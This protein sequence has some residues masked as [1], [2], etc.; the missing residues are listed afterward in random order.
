MNENYA[1]T[2]TG[3]TPGPQMMLAPAAVPPAG[4]S[5]DIAAIADAFRRRWWVVALAAL[6][7]GVLALAAA[8]SIE[9][10]Y[11]SHASV[12]V[13][14]G[15][16]R[17]LDFEDI[18]PED[19]SHL[20]VL[21]T[22]EQT[23]HSSSLLLRVADACGLRTQP[24]FMD[25]SGR[26]HPDSRLVYLLRTKISV[27][28]RRGTRLI[29][30]VVSDTVPER[31]RL[32]AATMVS[33][34]ERWEAEQAKQ[35]SELAHG[36]LAEQA[37]R[38]RGQL[39]A[40]EKELLAY[41]EEHSTLS[42]ESKEGVLLEKEKALNKEL[43]TAKSERLRLEADLEQIGGGADPAPE[44]VLALPSVAARPELVALRGLVSRKE[45]EFEM[46]KNRYK[47][48]HPSYIKVSSELEGLKDSLRREVALA[49]ASLDN[50]R[51]A[52]AD[53]EEALEEEL[54]RGRAELLSLKEVLVPYHAMVAEVETDR[55]L[56]AG[57][58]QRQKQAAAA[59]EV[60]SGAITMKEAPLASVDPVWPRKK[61]L[62]A[63]GLIAGVA[64][65]SGLVLAGELLCR[66][67]RTERQAERLLGMPMLASLPKAGRRGIGFEPSGTTGEA[68]R[69]LRTSLSFVG[70]GTHARTYLF[71]ST[72]AGEGAAECAANCAAAFARQGHRTLVIDADLRAPA[73]DSI[74]GDEQIGV[75]LAQYLKGGDEPG[76]VVNTTP[77]DNLY[78]LAAGAA[79]DDPA[80]LLSNGRLGQLVEE[81]K[82][83][84]HRIVISAPPLGDMGDGLPIAR[85]AESVCLV[86]EAASTPRAEVL[87]VCQL[88]GMA[89]APPVGFVL[90]GVAP[91]DGK[92]E[93]G[94]GRG[95]SRARKTV[96]QEA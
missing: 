69:T 19:L 89:G 64:V 80:G 82:Q 44:V 72:R 7:G 67:I 54:A 26:P 55:Q 41:R 23:F 61:L 76:K 14:Q 96:L 51:R 47:Y 58:R 36:A 15:K 31:A 42:L 78:L 57:V 2:G 83:W 93:R 16:L 20:E 27:D 91:G 9:P 4:S 77:I 25:P 12:E 86:V 87:R 63:L 3:E 68:F 43:A 6:A 11:V 48:K 79:P 88:L 29:D 85:Y 10:V 34:F 30:I 22:I 38:L 37:E 18:N 46:V 17:I 5:I 84:F 32:L 65:G 49:A 90:N 92:R 45:S 24:D 70:K 40:S 33:E 59:G 81:S 50:T 62:L 1:I 94:R 71:A 56:Y 66:S 60:E 74:I 53:K 21:K 28:L 75:G 95:K 73:V 52:L 8:L 13:E 39:H 35:I